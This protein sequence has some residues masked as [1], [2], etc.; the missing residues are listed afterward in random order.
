MPKYFTKS[1]ILFNT[2]WGVIFKQVNQKPISN[3]LALRKN[4]MKRIQLLRAHSYEVVLTEIWYDY[5]SIKTGSYM[6]YYH[7]TSI[8]YDI[9]YGI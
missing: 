3:N 2:L 6:E 8:S 9:V 7:Y 1:T 4:S 5:V